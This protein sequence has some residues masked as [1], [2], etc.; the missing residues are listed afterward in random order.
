MVSENVDVSQDLVSSQF[1]YDCHKTFVIDTIRYFCLVETMNCSELG[2]I[3]KMKE[4]SS[5]LFVTDYLG[6][7]NDK[8]TFTSDFLYF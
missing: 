5:R 7:E 1:M 8:Q 2:W 4:Q 3:S 6:K